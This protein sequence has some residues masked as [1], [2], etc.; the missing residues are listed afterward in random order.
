MV[1]QNPHSATYHCFLWHHSEKLKMKT[2]R[3]T[4]QH[5]PPLLKLVAQSKHWRPLNRLKL[6]D[7]LEALW[8]IPT[9][10]PLSLAEFQQQNIQHSVK[11]S[12]QW[13]ILETNMAT[14]NYL[15]CVSAWIRNSKPLSHWSLWSKHSLNHTA[16]SKN[17]QNF[18][19]WPTI[20]FC[21]LFR[22][23]DPVPLLVSIHY[24]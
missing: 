23:T 2:R 14:Q 20:F 10:A 17:T 13:C 12:K 7:K 16:G 22:F 8:L 11:V 18:W 19:P 9:L 3:L 15:V 5:L 4:I 21:I 1:A 24:N 6:S